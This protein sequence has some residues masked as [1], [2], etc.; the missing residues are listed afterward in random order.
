MKQFNED[1][2]HKLIETVE[3]IENNSL[4]EIIAVVKAKSENYANIPVW[5]ASVAMIISYT[6]LMFIHWEINVYLMYFISIFVF[7]GFYLLF[8]NI[9][10]LKRVF[11]SKKRMLR[12]TDIFS[13][14]VFQ[15]AGIRFTDQ[16]IGI[17]FFVSLF[18]KKVIVIPDRGALTAI[19]E[20]EW[21]LIIEDFRK[22]FSKKNS[23]D[24]FIS[25]L[26]KLKPIFNKYIPPIE[27][28]INE[29]PDFIEINF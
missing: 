9:N 4:V 27:N 15:K 21:N 23:A 8:E 7:I 18:E 14:A 20:D 19:P 10:M 22:I 28:D 12:A 29:L 16:K 5:V 6:F 13:R 26:L 17:L 25:K 11:V 2:K 3:D 24:E 1:F